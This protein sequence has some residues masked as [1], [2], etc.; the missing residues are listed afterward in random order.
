MAKAELGLMPWTRHSPQ[1]GLARPGLPVVGNADGKARPQL[2]SFP[3]AG[4]EGASQYRDWEAARYHTVSSTWDG[5]LVGTE[6][7][8]TG[9]GRRE[10]HIPVT[11]FEFPQASK[12]PLT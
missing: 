8:A 5:E 2:Q 10:I 6:L 3:E 1:G 7:R 4:A 12:D 9:S 11:P